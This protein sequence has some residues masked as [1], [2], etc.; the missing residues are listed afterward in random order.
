MSKT[1]FILTAALA[2][3]ALPAAPARADLL[4]AINQ[5]RLQGCNRVAGGKPP[6]RRNPVLDRVAEALAEGQDLRK[7][8]TSAGYRA[9]QSAMLEATG[10]PAAIGLSLA[11]RGCMDVINPIYSEIGIEQRPNKAWVVL[12]APFAPPAAS[13]A[14]AVS[15]KVLELVNQARAQPRRCGWKR[16]QVASPLVLS[17]T[18]QR[19]AADHARDMAARQKM[20]HSGGDGSTPAERATR[21]GYRWRFVGENVASGQATPES[22]V[23]EWLKSP[24]HCANIMDTD[25]T[26]LGVAFV[27]AQAGKSGIYW[28]QMFGAPAGQ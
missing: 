23:A 19:A 15:R 14:S 20:S 10:S 8:M 22:V 9:T 6:L 26:E 25:Y 24:Q 16:F 7:A 11:Q 17:N 2:M 5:V 4:G 13:D 28:V 21:A 1:A 27:T 18:L 12:A 3:L